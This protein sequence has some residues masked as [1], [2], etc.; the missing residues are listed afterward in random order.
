MRAARRENCRASCLAPSCDPPRVKIYEQQLYSDGATTEPFF[1]RVLA[2]MGSSGYEES[3]AGT[4]GT[5][6]C[7]LDDVDGRTGTQTYWFRV[8]E[9]PERPIIEQVRAALRPTR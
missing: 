1:S 6:V 4:P 3:D 5:Y 8:C 2:V 7:T 9:D